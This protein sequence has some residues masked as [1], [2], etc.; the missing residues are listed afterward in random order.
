[1]TT[2]RHEL[3]ACQAIVL[4]FRNF[5]L[6]FHQIAVIF[7]YVSDTFL[8]E[9]HCGWVEEEEEVNSYLMPARKKSPDIHIFGYEDVV[10][11]TLPCLST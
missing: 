7:G 8:S 4:V 11:I 10:I 3:R 9:N 6:R 1:M 2:G 5:G